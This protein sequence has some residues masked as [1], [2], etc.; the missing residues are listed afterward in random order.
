MLEWGDPLPTTTA[1]LTGLYHGINAVYGNLGTDV[2]AGMARAAGIPV[3]AQAKRQIKEVLMMLGPGGVGAIV[4]ATQVLPQE[5]AD[6]IGPMIA[7]MIGREYTAPGNPIVRTR[8]K[9]KRDKAM[10]RGLREA[11][12]KARKKNG[13]F[14]K[15]W[16]QSRVM[17]E[18]HRLA[19]K[20]GP[21]TKK[22]QVRKT[23]RRAYER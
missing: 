17:K 5:A 6:V 12:A 15:G 14:K 21:S 8:K 13:D 23:A 19:R 4:Q 10:S 16:N 1:Y 7:P 22:G 20:Y 18:A 2:L 3:N 9:T 11:Q